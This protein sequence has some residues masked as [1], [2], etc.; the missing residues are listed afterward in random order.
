MNQR[1]WKLDQY[2]ETPFPLDS[3]KISQ[4]NLNFES[5]TAEL[6]PQHDKLDKY[7][8]SRMNKKSLLFS[9]QINILSVSSH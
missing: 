8:K 4:M 7:K 2:E 9:E 1:R 3:Q 6:L 5:L